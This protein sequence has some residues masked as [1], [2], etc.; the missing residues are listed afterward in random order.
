MQ[1]PGPQARVVFFIYDSIASLHGSF[2]NKI[3]SDLGL[4]VPPKSKLYSCFQGTLK[5][6]TR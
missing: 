5:M 2:T 4:L 6:F 1:R 3:N